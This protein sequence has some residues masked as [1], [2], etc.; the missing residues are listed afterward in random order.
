MI[1]KKINTE[2][3]SKTTKKGRKKMNFKYNNKNNTLKI[4]Q[5]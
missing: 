3:Q 4:N 2:N 5:L 1:S